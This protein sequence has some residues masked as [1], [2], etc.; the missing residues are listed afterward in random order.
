MR[1]SIIGFCVS[2]LFLTLLILFAPHPAFA[3]AIANLANSTVATDWIV[4]DICVDA[5]NSPVPFDPY[6]ACPQGTARS[7]IQVG[8]PLPYHNIDQFN[9]QQADAFPLLDTSGNAL[10]FHTFDFAPFNQF[11][12][13]SGSD[14]YDYYSLDSWFAAAG[15]R[16]GGEY[17]EA[18]FGANCSTNDAWLFFPTSN[19]MA[20]GSV[21]AAIGG[22]SWGQNYNVAA[23]TCPPGYSN[24]VT[25]WE[26]KSVT[27]GGIN[28][29]PSKTMNAMISYHGF[30]PGAEA[31]M[32]V[33]WFTQQYGPTMW[34][35]WVPADQHPAKTSNCPVPDNISYNGVTYVVADCRD[36]SQTVLASDAEIPQWPLPGANML[37]H[38]NFDNEGGYLENNDSNFNLW[39]RG[40]NSAEGNEINWSLY[41]SSAPLDTRFGPGVRYLATNCAGTCTGAGVQEIYQDLPINSIANQG[42][43]LFGI[44][45]RSESDSGTLQVTL[46]EIDANGTVL[47]QDQVQ[48]TVAADNGD[49]RLNAVNGAAYSEASSVYLSTAFIHKTTVIPVYANAARMRFYITPLTPQTFDIVDT[50]LNRFPALQSGLG[51]IPAPIVSTPPPVSTPTPVSTPAPVSPPTPVTP[52]TITV[53]TPS[54]TVT[55]PSV[56]VTSPGQSNSSHGSSGS[57]G[58]AG[59]SSS[60]SSTSSSSTQESGTTSSSSNSTSSYGTSDD[61]SNSTSSRNAHSSHRRRS[62]WWNWW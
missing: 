29:N 10:Y 1:A 14:G 54:I 26:F 22:N 47:W 25:T 61:S 48:G 35:S 13:N 38:F 62:W 6:Y 49:G 44:D 16:D 23:S 57:S 46:Q 55:S 53:T 18:F 40:G 8:D 3:Q 28:G 33:F 27:F 9:Q 39:H 41:N 60:T 11:Q 30:V 37:Q 24:P 58:S 20:G 17:G 51:T 21:Q 4:K 7:K 43:Y 19:F 32:E 59:S 15:T 50:W 45:A 5:S 42:T 31:A 12:L 52:T 36:W 2:T 56:T 34:Q